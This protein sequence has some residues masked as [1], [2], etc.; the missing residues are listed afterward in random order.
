[1]CVCVYL[2]LVAEK[3]S[4]RVLC[5]SRCV[6]VCVTCSISTQD[7]DG[8][9]MRDPTLALAAEKERDKATPLDEDKRKQIAEFGLNPDDGYDYLKHLAPLGA[10]NSDC[11]YVI[12]TYYITVRC[13]LI[14][15]V[16]LL[17]TV[18]SPLRGGFG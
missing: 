6:S 4:C 18:V 13:I 11:V 10:S 7:L 3:W 15:Y 9:D 2:A 17:L 16:F 5:C 14:V 1:M 8:F 12:I